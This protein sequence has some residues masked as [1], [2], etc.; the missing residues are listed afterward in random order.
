MRLVL[1]IAG[2]GALGSVLRY[3]VAQASQRALGTGFPWG[4]LAVN[5]LGSLAIGLLWELAASGRLVSART[6]TALATG[7]LGGFT[8]FSAFSLEAV[9]MGSEG[10]RLG[11]AALYVGLSLAGGIAAVLAGSAMGRM[12]G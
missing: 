12:L 5:L 1:A 2:L 10:G 6:A 4:T 11:L 7:L 9:K 3:L 8:T